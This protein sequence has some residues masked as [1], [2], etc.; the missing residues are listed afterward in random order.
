M[1]DMFCSVVDNYGDVGVSWRLARVLSRDHGIPV[2]LWVDDM[3]AFAM[4]DPGAD[5]TAAVQTREG[6]EV[7]TWSKPFPDVQP[8]EVVIEAFGC[9]LP[10][11][12]LT[13]MAH[14]TPSPV[15]IN[16]EY[17]S[18]E[19]WVSGCHGLPSPH[20]RLPLH[21]YFFFP[22]FDA[23]TG[24][25]LREKG[26]IE[27][28]ERFQTNPAAVSAFWE[29]HGV[30]APTPGEMRVS[31]FCYDNPALPALF[32]T[33]SQGANPLTCLVPAGR[34]VAQITH[35]FGASQARAG[36]RFHRGTL[37][38]QILPFTD[39]SGYDRLLWACD[40]NFVRGED[41]FVRAQWAARPLVWHIYPQQENAHHAKLDAFLDRYCM[42]LP[43]AAARATRLLYGS[44]NSVPDASTIAA[45]WTD[46]LAH[47]NEAEAHASAWA[48]IRERGPS[49]AA[50]LVKFA[51]GQVK[52]AAF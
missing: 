47:R 27:T 28:R 8:G 32:E 22:G 7:R 15:W 43:P 42:D 52:Y 20:P 25:L 16:L 37:S 3:Q 4:L 46:W 14:A 19:D 11:R 39:Q 5:A 18:A 40:L 38:V 36:D 50:A 45:S 13:A 1:W 33:W 6:V 9:P 49:L 51:Q 29:S 2:R 12:Y 26:L 24:G 44:W 21:K 17:L 23:Q 41:S 34:T 48:Q 10:E 35:F 30:P 31:L